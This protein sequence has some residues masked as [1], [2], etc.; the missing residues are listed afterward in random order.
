MYIVYKP[1]LTYFTLWPCEPFGLALTL[2]LTKTMIQEY[3]KE[4]ILEFHFLV[5]K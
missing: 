3:L 4:Y 1:I 5:E 2:V